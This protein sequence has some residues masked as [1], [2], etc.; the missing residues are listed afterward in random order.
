[1][2]GAIIGDIVGSRFEWH[3]RKNKDFKFFHA[4]CFLTDDSIMTLAVARA[5]VDCA[6][7]YAA[8]SKRATAWMRRLGRQY[9][10][11]GYGGR[12]YQWLFNDRSGPYNSF[13]NG[14]A[15]RVSPCGFAAR[16]L[17]EVK[18]LSRQVTAVSHNHPEGLKG[19]EATA[20]C[21]F[22]ALQG[23]DIAEIRRA[24]AEYYVL[25]LTLDEIRPN[26]RFNETCQ[27]SVPQALTAFF[28]SAGFEDAIRNAISLGG[29]SD[30]LAAICGGVAGAYYGVPKA[31]RAGAL[32]FLDQQ[33]AAILNE[34]EDIYPPKEG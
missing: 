3:N 21:V 25:D 15:M 7:D 16:D 20:V 10:D 17:A 19:A 8:L 2:I 34:F 31:L 6:G 30:T 5:I 11:S 26:Y 32:N 22:L 14:A 27:D 9:P 4:D 33:Q 13:G 12:F 23:A 28:E 1:M 24:A 29:D 18:Y